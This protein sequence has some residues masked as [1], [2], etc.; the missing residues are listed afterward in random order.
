MRFNKG[1]INELPNKAA[2]LFTP[3]K[4]AVCGSGKGSLPH[5]LSVLA[6]DN[7]S[8]H[9]TAVK[10][11]DDG[12]GIILRYY[13][14]SDEPQTVDIK[15]SG[16]MYLCSLDE[17]VTEETASSHTAEAKKIVTVRIK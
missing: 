17:T 12:D 7:K 8:I 11:A 4:C 14:P 13:N 6:I 10:R 2:E 5:E 1:D 9:V 3:V 16:K 15:A